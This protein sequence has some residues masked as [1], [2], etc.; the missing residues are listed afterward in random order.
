M[1]SRLARLC[2]AA[3]LLVVVDAHA[4]AP[5]GPLPQTPPL[6]ALPAQPVTPAT[7]PGLPV[8]SNTDDEPV[9]LKLPGADI[10]TVLSALH[11]YTGKI[12]L[13]PSALPTAP[14]GFNLTISRPIP[15]SEAIRYIE[16]ILALNNIAVIPMGSDA[17]KVVPLTQARI[18]APQL[19]QGSTLGLPPSSKIASKLFELK[20]L[21]VQEFQ[22]MLG[23][24]TNPNFGQA[25]PLPNA[26]AILVTDTISNLQRIETLLKQVDKPDTEGL[27]PRFY[28]LHHAKASDVVNKLH[29]ILTG[30]IQQQLGQITTYTADD[31]TN[32]IVLI[33]D[34]RQ[35]PLFDRLI[36]KLDVESDPNTRN[37]VIYLKHAKAADVVQVL[38]RIIQ[39]QSQAAQKLGGP[40]AQL[41]PTPTA[42]SAG[43]P[44]RPAIPAIISGTG[45]NNP[46]LAA[47]GTNE[48]SPFV[49][50][51]NDDRSNSIVVS[52]TVDD[53]RLIDQLVKKLDIVLAQV[54]IEVVI[55]EVTLDNNHQSGIDQLG[56][57]LSGDKLVGFSLAG[58]TG[59]P[60]TIGGTGSNSLATITRNN[61]NLDLAGLISLGTYPRKTN[62]TILTIPSIVTSHGKKATIVDG[63]TRP[64]IT[65]SS[66]YAGA[67]AQPITSSQVT[68]LQI[69]TTLTV[70][71]YIGND[72]S[73]QLDIQTELSNVS[74]TV[75][76]DGNTQ[77][78]IG[79]RKTDSYITAK[80]GDIIVMGGFRQDQDIKNSNRLGGI[81][82]IGDLL[83]SRKKDVS[84]QELIFFLRPTV[85]TN[86]PKIDNART[87]KRVDQL[88]T[89][90]EIKEALDPNYVAPKKSLLD[91]ILPH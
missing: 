72:G 25:V 33:T 86:N 22:Q 62:T 44:A 60:V 39:G 80:S 91:R 81:P 1:T 51:V 13:H 63:E 68:Q 78:V 35:F 52:G 83:G 28:A 89:K 20:F 45:A 71:P 69:G 77:Y 61:G 57:E 6:R 43:Q 50:V 70:T 8:G 55:A 23:T 3:L 15:K 49:T 42:T 48:F 7:R 17:L 65:G 76:I 41:Q 34:P 40:E 9:L 16:T 90:N 21:R 37:D 88:P 31:R 27:E 29:A 38:V 82:I 18:E 79:T 11:I 67:G 64:V 53:I 47:G 32:Q 46:A 12:I 59:S 87:M 58:G 5:G 85:L 73:V 30:A 66:N 4:Q 2:L 36:S 19:I 75:T 56:L 54:Q 26:N 14:G 74:S 24:I 10:D 84:H